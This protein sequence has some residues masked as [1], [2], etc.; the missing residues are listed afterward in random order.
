MHA[1]CLQL[2][3]ALSPVLHLLAAIDSCESIH[4]PTPSCCSSSVIILSLSF[5]PL[6]SLLLTYFVSQ[7]CAAGGAEVDEVGNI[8][9]GDE[10]V[11]V[12]QE[13]AASAPTLSAE[14]A[15]QQV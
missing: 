12:T 3:R 5:H 10:L 7:I 15:E 4:S 14:R 13:R 9:E 11:G 2:Q 1:E 8:L 6:R